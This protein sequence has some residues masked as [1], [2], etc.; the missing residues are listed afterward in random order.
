MTVKEINA[1]IKK[2]KEQIDVLNIEIEKVNQEA[3]KASTDLQDA[4]IQLCELPAKIQP[5][6]QSV[7]KN[8]NK[9][10]APD[11]HKKNKFLLPNTLK[12]LLSVESYRIGLHF[13]L[14]PQ[15]RL[16]SF[17]NEIIKLTSKE[18]HLLVMFAANQNVILERDYLLKEVWVE[19]T[20]YSSRSMD[21]YICKMRKYLSK[22]DNVHLVNYH[23]KGYTLLVID[24]AS[25]K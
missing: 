2:I 17:K 3:L 25:N 9:L 1:K 4:F 16:L 23:G 10:K 8:I 19:V 18:L 15:S 21:V 20:Y 6:I 22:D 14:F 5:V 11:I 13:T 12:T 7:G 24:E